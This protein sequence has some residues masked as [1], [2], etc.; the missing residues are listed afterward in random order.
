MRARSSPRPA[1][2]RPITVQPSVAA[3]GACWRRQA[4]SVVAGTRTHG[5]NPPGAAAVSTGA[6]PEPET[7]IDTGIEPCGDGRFPHQDKN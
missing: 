4:M 7:S 5:N 6:G 2:D 3:N 1:T